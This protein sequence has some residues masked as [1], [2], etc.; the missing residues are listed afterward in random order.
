MPY[1]PA[2]VHPSIKWNKKD[3]MLDPIADD[4]PWT[5]VAKSAKADAKPENS[6]CNAPKLPVYK[7]PDTPVKSVK[8]KEITPLKEYTI[9]I[10]KYATPITTPCKSKKRKEITPQ[11][12]HKS[13]VSKTQP[14]LSIDSTETYIDPNSLIPCGTAWHQNSCAY[15]AT[16]CIVHAIWSCNKEQYIQIFNNMNNEIMSNLSSNFLQHAAGRKTLDSTRDDMRHYLH[17]L[18]PHNFGW[19]QFTS[20]CHLLKYMLTYPTEIMNYKYK[21]TNN[22]VTNARVPD[23]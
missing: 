11:K 21:C 12:E 10:T 4:M 15:D 1:V 18:S 17:Q 20:A 19:G 14:I 13:K 8:V 23:K 7:S 2:S 6:I 3:P 22:H 9:N 5:I 16:L